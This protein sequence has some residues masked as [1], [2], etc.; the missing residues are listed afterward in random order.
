MRCAILSGCHGVIKKYFDNRWELQG[1]EIRTVISRGD[2]E[3]AA[4]I[5]G[6][7][8]DI[9]TKRP[10]D[11]SFLEA[12]LFSRD[13]RT[14]NWAL[15]ADT[16]YYDPGALCATV[17]LALELEG[18]L[19]YKDV[20]TRRPKTATAH[21]LESTAV[22]IAASGNKIQLLRDLLSI[23]PRSSYCQM[24]EGWVFSDE[25]PGP[26]DFAFWKTS[27]CIGSPLTYALGMG[28]EENFA[29]M[30][31]CGYQPDEST[32]LRA[33]NVGSLEQIKFIYGSGV[34]DLIVGS[35]SCHSASKLKVPF[36]MSILLQTAAR[37]NRTD[38][39]QWLLT[40]NLV[41]GEWLE[42]W[43]LKMSPLQYAVDN[44]NLE[45]ITMLLRHG[46]SPNEEPKVYG[47]TALQLAAKRGYI[48]IAKILISHEPPADVNAHRSE[49]QG[50]TALES[51][52]AHGSLDMVQFLLCNG[53]KT[54]GTGQRQ[55]I[56]AIKPARSAQCI[57][58]V[59]ILMAHRKWT[60][61]DD[62]LLIK[63]DIYNRDLGVDES[64]CS[65][66]ER[67]QLPSFNY[68]SW[69][70]LLVRKWVCPYNLYA[71][72]SRCTNI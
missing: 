42:H 52:A 11:P 51:A 61:Q 15:A 58:I 49:L 56:R 71:V 35:P 54:E 64:E 48:G 37:Q 32:L 66:S 34:G 68:Q 26:N 59:K 63:E 40:R 5:I 9:K 44:G 19:W 18:V 3:T 2:T 45:L 69:H 23:I 7:G 6:L 53:A 46:I 28:R 39:I 13:Q 22:G 16:E 47:S 25:F 43:I 12:A 36:T 10:N 65:D 62:E 14:I 67:N 41:I 20:L 1:D 55:Y 33:I 57:E 30:L 60:Q 29:L 50:L 38:V 72:F 21:I 31:E 4:A 24:K 8:I 70:L 17:R 27:C